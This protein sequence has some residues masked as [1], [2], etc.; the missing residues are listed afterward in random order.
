MKRW[1]MLTDNELIRYNRQILFPGFG[2][3]GQLKL[4]NSHVV[5]AGI[6]GL[7]SPAS[8][9]LASAG[10]GHIA[11]VDNDRVELSNLNR[12]VLH[13][14]KDI[15]EKKVISAQRK[16]SEL[17]PGIEIIP[18]FKKIT[19]SNVAAIIKGANVV[20]DGMDNFETRFVLNSGCV[21]E[22]I[23]FIHGAIHGLSGE[24]T[25]IIPGKTPCYACIYPE[26]PEA[27]KAFPVFGATPALIASLQVMEAIKL[28]AGLENLLMGKMLFVDGGSME[29][30]S[31]ELKKTPHCKVC[32]GKF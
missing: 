8:L 28:I 21:K 10:V 7:G 11:I 12:Q 1:Y 9:Y 23:P 2:E 3:E 27:K 32:G 17:N 25:T 26:A 6:G 14:D 29:F 20:I 16:L 18:I 15:G 30:N 31:I 5:V 22:K 13:W 19:K 24:I 4:R